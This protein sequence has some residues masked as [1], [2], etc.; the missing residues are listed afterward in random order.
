MES[1]SKASS[2]KSILV[3]LAAGTHSWLP[4]PE[5]E[6]FQEGILEIMGKHGIKRLDT[7]RLYVCLLVHLFLLGN[8]MVLFLKSPTL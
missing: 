7:A 2:E 1:I 6:A 8:L 4:T 3:A 5:N